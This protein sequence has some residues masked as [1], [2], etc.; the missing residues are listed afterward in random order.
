M[1]IIL[2]K[3]AAMKL[4]DTSY[5]AILLLAIFAYN[6][7]MPFLSIPQIMLGARAQISG[8]GEIRP[9]CLF[10]PWYKHC[11]GGSC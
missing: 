6:S 4:G 3:T 10:P 8:M 11:A 5:T 1:Y 7:P 2:K 9:G